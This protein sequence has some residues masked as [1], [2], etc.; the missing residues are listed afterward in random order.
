M[1]TTDVLPPPNVIAISTSESP[2]MP[3]LG[4]SDEHLR[5]A[6]G[7]IALHLLADG[8]DLVYGG[9]WRQ[10]GFT[11]LLFELLDRYRRRT[12][13]N[14]EARVTN[15][16]AWPVHIVMTADALDGV[17]SGLHRHA[18]IVLIGQDG[19][20]IT[21][22]E[23]RKMPLHEPN[24]HEW[25]EGLT[26]MRKIVC[27]ETDARVVLGGRVNDYNGKMPGIAEEVL[28]SFEL[29]LPVFLL[30]GFGGCTRDIAET[31][32]LVDPWSGSRSAW[33][34]R[35]QFECY[36]PDSL[37]NGLSREENE[38]LAGSPHVSQ[39]VALILR[40]LHHLRKCK[41][42]KRFNTSA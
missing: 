31:L 24:D 28:L 9:D 13:A 10:H 11:N 38:F 14:L 29:G 15:Y 17:V 12:N 33:P 7:E 4:L 26:T 20:Q 6:M 40:G 16:L 27:A 39:A 8:V 2:D 32:G 37:R 3:V 23:R 19:K 35:R 5:G 41:P 22:E 30:G 18:R 1:T 25:S 21:I 36:G 34:G 42:Y